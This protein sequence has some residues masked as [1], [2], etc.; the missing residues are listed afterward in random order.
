MAFPIEIIGAIAVVFKLEWSVICLPILLDGLKVNQRVAAPV[1]EFVLGKIRRDG[2]NPSRKFLR[3][4]EAVQVTVY[5]DENL[6]HQVFTALSITD[7]SVD[8][9]QQSTLVSLD[10]LLEGQGVAGQMSRDNLGI[11]QLA[12]ERCCLRRR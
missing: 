8:E 12:S 5:A 9:V 2:V 1:A 3:L 6:L 7:R 4:V 11:G 10:Q